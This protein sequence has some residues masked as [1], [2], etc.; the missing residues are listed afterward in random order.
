MLVFDVRDIRTQDTLVARPLV[1]QYS[2]D[3]AGVTAL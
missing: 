1:H 2:L 3:G